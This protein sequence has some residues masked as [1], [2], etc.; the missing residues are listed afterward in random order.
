MR[1]HRREYVRAIAF[2]FTQNSFSSASNSGNSHLLLPAGCCIAIISLYDFAF[3][4][5]QLSCRISGSVNSSDEHD[6]TWANVWDFHDDELPAPHHFASKITFWIAA[7]GRPANGKYR[8]MHSHIFNSFLP[9]QL[10]RANLHH[11]N[12]H[13][14]HC[15]VFLGPKHKYTPSLLALRQTQSQMH[16]TNMKGNFE[17]K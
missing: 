13:R 10:A 7:T 14:C 17:R 8:L 12:G 2:A 11:T 6:T 3:I 16:A 15:Y 9:R 4:R 1:H 5:L